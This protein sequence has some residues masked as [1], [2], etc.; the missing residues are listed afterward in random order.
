MERL[1]AKS[2]RRRWTVR[3]RG[4]PCADAAARHQQLASDLAGTLQLAMLTCDRPLMFA[5]EAPVRPRHA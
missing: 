3:S 5:A 1:G 2:G 4:A